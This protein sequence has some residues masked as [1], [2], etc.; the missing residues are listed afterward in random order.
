MCNREKKI[1]FG[2]SK[3]K[4]AE[5]RRKVLFQLKAEAT[6]KTKL[7]LSKVI[8]LF[9]MQVKGCEGGIDFEFGPYMAVILPG[10]KANWTLR[11]VVL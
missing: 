7:W 2:G 11:Y 6:R 10:H 1:L 3:F 4:Q 9:W 5:I 8:L